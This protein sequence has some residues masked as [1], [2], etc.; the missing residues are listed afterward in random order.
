MAV[1]PEPGSKALKKQVR[2]KASFTSPFS[3]KWSPLLPKDKD[4]ILRT[5]KDKI[6]ATGLK[7]EE[8]KMP[9]QWRKKKENKPDVAAEPVPQASEEAQ[10]PNPT[11]NGWKDTAARR[12]LAIGINE[13]T[14]ALE[15]N[16]LRLLLV[17]KSPPTSTQLKKKKKKVLD[18]PSQT[19]NSNYR[20]KW[21][22]VFNVNYMLQFL[23]CLVRDF[24]CYIYLLKKKCFGRSLKH[25]FTVSN[26]T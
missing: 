16:Q 4:F 26:P 14:K 17:C 9:H 18:Q 10:G 5:L 12:Q 3:A 21:G 11:R 19:C 1:H 23:C 8:V 13:V 6:I 7:K 15:R 22:F 2:S 20:N 24:L 25:F